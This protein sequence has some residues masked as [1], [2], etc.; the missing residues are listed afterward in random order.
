MLTRVAVRYIEGGRAE[1]KPYASSLKPKAVR[2]FEFA[3]VWCV[4]VCVCVR[5]RVVLCC[6]DCA[7]LILSDMLLYITPG[8]LYT[9]KKAKQA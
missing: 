9:A 7:V 2:R 5:A 1:L 8:E 4:C 3:C 6:V